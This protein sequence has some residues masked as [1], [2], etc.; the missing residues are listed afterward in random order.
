MIKTV[1]RKK[2]ENTPWSHCAYGGRGG[3]GFY[4]GKQHVQTIPHR[5]FKLILSGDLFNCFLDHTTFHITI[6]DISND[7]G[8]ET[9]FD[10]FK[11]YD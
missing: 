6:L 2:K 3:D 7:I 9:E 8:R 4:F 5:H 11:L 1:R 10:K